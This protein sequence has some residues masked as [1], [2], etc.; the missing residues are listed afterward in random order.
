MKYILNNSFSLFIVLPIIFVT[1][2]LVDDFHSKYTLITFVVITSIIFFFLTF[3]FT[4]NIDVFVFTLIFVFTLYAMTV[5]PGWGVL[6]KN[7]VFVVAVLY[8]IWGIHKFNLDFASKKIVINSVWKIIFILQII[9]LIISICL[10]NLKDFFY[11]YGLP[12]IIAY[13]GSAIFFGYYLPK[14]IEKKVE[15]KYL[16][17]KGII[18]AGIVSSIGGIITIFLNVNP[19]YSY[20]NSS[21]SFFAHVNLPSFLYTFSIPCVLYLIYFEKNNL[22]YFSRPILNL[23]LILM[24]INMLF[25]FNRSGIISMFVGITFM[26]IFY[27]RKLLIGMILVIIPLSSFLLTFLI[28]KGAG[29]ILARL[30]LYTVSFEMMRSSFWGFLF[31]F[32]VESNFLLFQKIKTSNMIF[33]SH[34]YP[35]NGYIF[36]ILQFGIVPLIFTL[37]SFV[38]L[39]S[40]S[41]KLLFQKNSNKE[42]ILYFSIILS[43]VIY[44]FFE[45]FFLFPENFMYHLT[46][47]FLGMLYINIKN[48]RRIN[49]Q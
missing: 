25:T 26:T 3:E 43:V 36:F 17:I 4:K 9:S 29:T 23:A 16:I 35:H 44:S 40:K 7:S 20:P 49:N 42:I 12:K 41:V 1:I 28:T 39:F 34:N 21:I 13:L 33:D 22:N 6:N 47:F 37:L 48:Q 14:I 45:D 38:I 46:W 31:G 5:L 15:L 11:T 10:F 30:Q 24:V 8:V 32:G 18:I 19:Y 2:I 27:S